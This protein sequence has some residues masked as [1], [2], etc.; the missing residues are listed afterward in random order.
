MRAWASVVVEGDEDVDT[1]GG[2]GVG[3]QLD[4][5][6]T[7]SAAIRTHNRPRTTQPS[8]KIPLTPHSLSIDSGFHHFILYHTIRDCEFALFL[9]S[10]QDIST[11]SF[12]SQ[13]ALL[14]IVFSL[15]LR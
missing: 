9:N 14:A 10:V 5:E 2:D 1:S 3:D 13:V 7:A 12:F 15:S 8:Y 6:E 11:F 4:G